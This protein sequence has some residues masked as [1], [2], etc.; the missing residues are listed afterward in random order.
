MKSAPRILAFIAT[1]CLLMLFFFPLWRIT[2]IAPQYPD[3]VTMYIWIHQITGTSPGTLQNINI[4]N[5]YVGMKMIEP[6]S[7]PEL[8]YFPWVVGG[9]G[10]MGFLAGIINRSKFYLSWASVFLILAILGIYDFYLWE[11]DYG[12]NLSPTAPIKVP[13]QSYQPPLFGSKM[14]LNFNAISY[15]ATG[16]IFMGIA[17][18]LSILASWIRIKLNKLKTQS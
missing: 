16:G 12:H 13:G 2:L 3:G 15:P 1:A 17:L 10:L 18:M 11:Y 4:L 7:I 6:N 9:L 5:H 14:L 8:S